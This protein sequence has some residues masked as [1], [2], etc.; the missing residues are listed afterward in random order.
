[1]N[2]TPDMI[3]SIVRSRRCAATDI[4]ACQHC[5]Q[6]LYPPN[7][8]ESDSNFYYIFEIERGPCT[9]A[10]RCCDQGGPSGKDHPPHIIARPRRD[11]EVTKLEVQDAAAPLWLV[12]ESYLDRWTGDITVDVTKKLKYGRQLVSSWAFQNNQWQ[13][14][15]HEVGIVFPP[16]VEQQLA[17]AQLKAT[18][19]CLRQ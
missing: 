13:E 1:M 8:G 11:D 5:D 17:Q 12:S 6:P 16:E 2:I 14:I 10:W 4:A 3:H 15:A 19:N 18:L 7:Q 9:C